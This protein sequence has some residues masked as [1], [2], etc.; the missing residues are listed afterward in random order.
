M[1]IA[2]NK[3]KP[4]KFRTNPYKIKGLMLLKGIEHRDAALQ[5]GISGTYLSYVI[6]GYRYAANVRRK[7]AELLGVPYETLWEEEEK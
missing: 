1:I 6:H 2:I 3:K 4:K 5:L 7:I